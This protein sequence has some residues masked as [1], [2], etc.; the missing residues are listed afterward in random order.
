M[1][2]RLG[3]FFGE[4]EKPMAQALDLGRSIAFNR[5]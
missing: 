4:L 5:R 2:W 3:Q 1:P